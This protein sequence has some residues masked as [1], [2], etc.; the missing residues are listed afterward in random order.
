MSEVSSYP[1][2]SV[3]IPYYKARKTIERTLESVY[4][5]EWPDVEVVVV[6]DGSPDNSGPFLRSL[7]T[8]S[9]IPFVLLDEQ[10][11]RKLPN[12]R[13]LGLRAASGEF[14]VFLDADDRL[15]PGKIA[16]QLPFLVDNGFDFVFSDELVCPQ[17]GIP[18]EERV[19]PRQPKEDDTYFI[20]RTAIQI[21]MALFRKSAVNAAGGFRLV[22]AEDKDLFFR[23]V[24]NGARFGYIPG[25]VNEYFIVEDSRTSD[26]IRYMKEGI[27]RNNW[28]LVHNR[29][30]KAADY[31]AMHKKLIGAKLMSEAR[32]WARH[33]YFKQALI[34]YRQAKRIDPESTPHGTPAY[35]TGVRFLGFLPVEV[36]RYLITRLR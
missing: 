10:K 26:E 34:R 25:L 31:S 8:G 19:Y 1:R 28:L 3:I 36:G 35:Q 27:V 30:K 4:A 33:G 21:S 16:L 2:V 6:N 22:P 14:I 20:M 15:L 23:M 13:N 11:N 29:L 5:L 17:D 24:R 12:A 32:T 18:Y 7:Q 9:P